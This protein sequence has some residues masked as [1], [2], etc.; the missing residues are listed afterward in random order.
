MQEKEAAFKHLE[1]SLLRIGEKTWDASRKYSLNKVQ[2]SCFSFEE[3]GE[4]SHER[5]HKRKKKETEDFLLDKMAVS[6]TKGGRARPSSGIRGKKG[7]YA[8]A[9]SMLFIEKR[10]NKR[11]FGGKKKSDEAVHHGEKKRFF[12][13][14]G[15]ARRMVES[16]HPKK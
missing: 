11:R 15:K 13:R 16:V 4:D 10:R 9:M 2:M 6:F 3:K 5:P 8:K 1:L 12:S 14:K 7:Q